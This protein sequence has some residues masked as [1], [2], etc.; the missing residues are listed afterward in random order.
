MSLDSI[1]ADI[2][3][4]E[5]TCKDVDEV[6]EYIRG[7]LVEG[8]RLYG[9]GSDEYA[10]LLNDLAGYEREKRHL[11]DSVENF[12]A[13]LQIQIDNAA[14]RAVEAST[15]RCR[16]CSTVP[17][18]EGI[19]ADP[20]IATTLLNL[21]GTYRLAEDFE[22]AEVCFGTAMGIYEQTIGTD[23]PIYCAALNNLALMRQDQKRY[24][25]ALDLHEQGA[26][27]LAN[28]DDPAYAEYRATNAYNR[29]FCRYLM[30]GD[31]DRAHAELEE[32]KAAYDVLP[33]SND[34]SIG[35]CEDVLAKVEEAQAAQ[36]AGKAE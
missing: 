16:A 7:K 20:N 4:K 15:C 11:E 34:W 30:G 21:G 10:A 17:V 23:N 2:D 32:A 31:L 35:R 5:R 36:T 13:A 24:Q 1:R 22:Q 19:P 14:Q 8:G 6:V 33:G 28:F 12:L 3:A 29:G 18:L 9:Y 27:I 25:E 26:K